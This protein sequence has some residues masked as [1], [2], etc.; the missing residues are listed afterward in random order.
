M[1][2][3]YKRF[4]RLAESYVAKFIFIFMFFIIA[5]TIASEYLDVA[6]F[7][8]VERYE[9]AFSYMSYMM[10]FFFAFFLVDKEQHDWIYAF[11]FIRRRN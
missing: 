8:T 3:N 7:G 9:G 2:F 11:I 6:V 4:D 1:I 5:S 10:L